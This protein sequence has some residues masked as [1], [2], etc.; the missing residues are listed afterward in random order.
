LRFSAKSRRIGDLLDEERAF[1]TKPK[2]FVFQIYPENISFIES[3]SYQEKQLIINELISEYRQGND[4]PNIIT[5]LINP[6]KKII[7]VLVSALI[8]VSFLVFITSLA[9][10]ATKSTDYSMQRNF[11]KLF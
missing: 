6:Y 4:V 1:P 11:E 5:R 3:L 8:V 10:T 7:T 9:W 2:K